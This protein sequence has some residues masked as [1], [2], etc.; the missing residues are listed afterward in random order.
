MQDTQVIEASLDRP[1]AVALRSFI[2]KVTLGDIPD[3]ET[4]SALRKL[5]IALEDAINETDKG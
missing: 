1:E 3:V 5:F 2:G 4:A